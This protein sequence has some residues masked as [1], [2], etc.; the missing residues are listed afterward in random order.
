MYGYVMICIEGIYLTYRMICN[1]GIHL[2][3]FFF[4]GF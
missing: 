3:F 1:E 2:T 4:L